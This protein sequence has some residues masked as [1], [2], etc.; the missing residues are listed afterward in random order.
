VRL[1]RSLK[2]TARVLEILIHDHIIVGENR[3]YSFRE[4]GIMP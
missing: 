4:E 1:T 3:Y 2:E